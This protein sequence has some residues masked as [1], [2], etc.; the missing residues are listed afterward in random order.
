[1]PR[2]EQQAAEADASTWVGAQ[3]ATGSFVQIGTTEDELGTSTLY[4]VFW[5]DPPATFHPQY[6][7]LVAAGDDI[8]ASMQQS[9]SG[10][11]LQV[12]DTTTG[13]TVSHR[14][15]YAGRVHFQQAEWFQ[16]DPGSSC[17]GN[18]P[19]PRLSP[20]TFNDLL[21]D[22]SAP[23]LTYADGQVL[24]A[25]NGRT[26]VPSQ[27]AANSFTV[28]APTGPQAR[29]LKIVAAYDVANARLG[30]Y[31]SET[32]S[33]AGKTP[34]PTVLDPVEAALRKTITQLEAPTWPSG[35]QPKLRALAQRNANYLSALESST[36]RSAYDKL[37]TTQADSAS[38]ANA[39]RYAL[40]LPPTEPA[41]IASD[42]GWG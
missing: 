36:V 9:A 1:V 22:G 34:P 29:Y 4:H 3:S 42:T 23:K 39:V 12:A 37:R 32:G 38:V 28:Q 6:L 19:Y 24:L 30:P 25:A 20:V 11:T 18:A 13:R 5:S 27:I 7:M 35:L 15:D 33:D 10:W 17:V 14:V 40:G 41:S 31:Q 21:D 26:A 2:I 16:E 8:E